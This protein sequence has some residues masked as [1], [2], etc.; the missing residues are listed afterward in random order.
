MSC[1]S[2]SNWADH[3]WPLVTTLYWTRR[4]T[5]HHR[6]PSTSL[7][8]DTCLRPLTF[9]RA[10]LQWAGGM[11]EPLEE[12]GGGP[13]IRTELE[14]IQMQ[15]NEQTD[16]VRQS[17]QGPQH[18]VCIVQMRWDNHYKG[19]G[20]W[21]AWYRW[22]ETIITRATASGVHGT[23]EV[24]QSLQG[25]RHLVCMV[26]GRGWDNHYKGHGIWCAWYRWGETIIT[27][28]MASGVHGTWEGVRQSLQGPRHLAC[29]VHGRGCSLNAVNGFKTM[30]KPCTSRSPCVWFNGRGLL[31][32][33]RTWGVSS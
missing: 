7:H 28:A 33:E 18:L 26:H 20:I 13:V 30:D 24:R 5:T 25:P 19:H 11:A 23:D 2:S 10:V 9:T 3:T 8:I 29:M 21:C 4:V 16:E 27:R 6:C 15:M 17:L 12:N 1:F 14:E 32:G 22:G 31:H